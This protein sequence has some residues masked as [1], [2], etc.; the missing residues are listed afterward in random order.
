VMSGRQNYRK[1]GRRQSRETPAG[2]ER[3]AKT[4]NSKQTTESRNFM[5]Q[6]IQRPPQQTN[7]PRHPVTGATR[8]TTAE[9]AQPRRGPTPEQINAQQR[10]TAEQ[11]TRTAQEQQ[12][13]ARNRA[14]ATS[15]SAPA[16]PTHGGGQGAQTAMESVLDE[17]A[18]VSFIGRPARFDGKDGIHKTKDDGQEMAE[19]PY[20]F[21]Y[22][23]TASLWVR[24]NGPGNPAD[25]VGGYLYDPAFQDTPREALG[26]NDPASWPIGMSGTAEDTWKRQL[27]LVLEQADTH[28]LFTWIAGNKTSLRAAGGLIRHCNRMFESAGTHLP[29]IFLKA[30]G[31]THPTLN[32]RV[33]TPTLQ[34]AGRVPRDDAASPEKLA[35]AAAPAEFNDEIPFK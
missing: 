6:S 35:S 23:Q 14:L 22:P 1:T 18:P 16:V 15:P 9:T 10:A 33:P 7:P 31:Y 29:L 24:F 2:S 13:A 19:G 34:I 4:P 26:D 30:G 20:I 32:T 28:E 3:R 21:H 27:Y 12:A 8:T 25:R 17:I 5:T 11:I